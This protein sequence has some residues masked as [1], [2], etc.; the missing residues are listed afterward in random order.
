MPSILLKALFGTLLFLT[1]LTFNA[2][3]RRPSP[4]P[5]SPPEQSRTGSA[6]NLPAGVERSD[7]QGILAAH[8]EW[9]HAIH[10]PRKRRSPGC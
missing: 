3:D 1:I 10:Q 8:E 9:K 5:S 6:E 7:W 2:S 4:R